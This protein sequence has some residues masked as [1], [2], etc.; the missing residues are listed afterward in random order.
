M[1]FLTILQLNIWPDL[2]DSAC[3]CNYNFI[4]FSVSD[5]SSCP[6]VPIKIFIQGGLSW[7]V[8]IAV[9]LCLSTTFLCSPATPRVFWILHSL[10]LSH[11]NLFFSVRSYLTAPIP[12]IPPSI[13][14]L[15]IFQG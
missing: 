7:L 14:Y 6:T 4:F 2:Y 11:L 15:L 9:S 3:D 12:I 13:L 5:V 8:A 1:I 10:C